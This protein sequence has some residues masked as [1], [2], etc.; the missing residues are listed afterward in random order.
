[1]GQAVHCPACGAETLLGDDTCASCSAPLHEL[2]NTP[3]RDDSFMARDAVGSLPL[4]APHT[5]APEVS[6]REA[7]G[8]LQASSDGSVLVLKGGRLA[9]I[10][11]ERDLLYKVAGCGLDLDATPVSQVMTADP[12]RVTVSDKVSAA[13]HQMAVGGFRHVPVLDGD[14][15]VGQVTMRL[16]LRYL[17]EH[18]PAQ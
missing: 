10:V 4:P 13:F 6:L 15:V 9:G 2:D 7:I 11:T 12:V 3:E 8:A 17:R 18:A 14:R 5:V 16:L 1:M